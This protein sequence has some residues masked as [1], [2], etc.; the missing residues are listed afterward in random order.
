MKKLFNSSLIAF[1]IMLT[2]HLNAQD[3]NVQSTA[4]MEF[5]WRERVL[6]DGQQQFYLTKDGNQLLA[7]TDS[8]W[9]IFDTKAGQTI[10]EGEYVGKLNKVAEKLNSDNSGI[11]GLIRF[12]EGSAFY[13]V[14]EKDIVVFLDWSAGRNIVKAVQL[15]TGDLLWEKVNEYKIS[16]SLSKQLFTSLTGFGNDNLD[17]EGDYTSPIL[18]G[19]QLRS[20]GNN[21]YLNDNASRIASALIRYLPSQNL[22]ALSTQEGLLGVS[23]QDGSLIWSL[24]VPELRM[25][26][27]LSI[28]NSDD[29]LFINRMSRFDGDKGVEAV[30]DNKKSGEKKLIYRLNPENGDVIWQANYWGD[31]QSG[32]THIYDNNL[33]LDYTVVEA[34]NMESGERIFCSA[35]EKVAKVSNFMTSGKD[36]LNVKYQAINEA[37]FYEDFVYTTDFE[38]KFNVGRPPSYVQ[39]FNFQTGE[40]LWQTDKMDKGTD[41]YYANANYIVLENSSGIAKTS[42]QVLNAANGDM[43][44]ET[45]EIKNY[46]FRNGAGT[47]FTEEVIFRT[48]RKNTYTY[49]PNSFQLLN[50]F[51]TN[52]AGV[53]KLQA[54]F[55]TDNSLIYI[56][57]KG[58]A[59]FNKQGKLNNTIEAKRVKAAYWNSNYS[60]IFDKEEMLVV[61]NKSENQVQEL[62]VP[63]S[64]DHLYFFTENAEKL[65]VINPDNKSFI[66]Y[67]K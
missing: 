6:S 43:V 38:F 12:D 57:D 10:A 45:E 32:R 4:N 50:K 67:S 14:E 44:F 58:L 2:F 28:P 20:F 3:Y 7:N 37:V 55:P 36:G 62:P 34:Y 18:S 61:D 54:M 8:R 35:D 30:F 21:A 11:A 1:C 59:F 53:G 16:T 9:V 66:V 41:V 48:G 40:K 23:L 39:K 5:D 25:G 42:L 46:W 33:V 52:K 56:A 26:E 27:L 24:E 19:A 63:Y 13:V 65:A 64:E 47:V 31:F 17:Q 51:E 49:N 60:Y 29:V 15:S 22:I